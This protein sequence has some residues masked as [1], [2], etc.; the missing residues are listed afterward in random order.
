MVAEKCCVTE[1]GHIQTYKQIFWL[2]S[3]IVG[4]SRTRLHLP[5]WLALHEGHMY[6]LWPLPHLLLVC[7]T[8]V[9]VHY[10]SMCTVCGH[11][12]FYYKSVVL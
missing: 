9:Y 11:S 2:L 12:H 7:F 4:Y 3:Y 5:L 8:L 10:L 1:K 6:C